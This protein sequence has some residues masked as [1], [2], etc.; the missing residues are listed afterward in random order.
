MGILRNNTESKLFTKIDKILKLL[1]DE[2]N[3]DQEIKRYMTY[4]TTSPLSHRSVNYKG[5]I[6]FQRDL[7]TS[8][9]STQKIDVSKDNDGSKIVTI[10]QV[11]FPYPYRSD[12]VNQEYCTLFISNYIYD[13]DSTISENIYKLDLI[14]PSYL[15]VLKPYGESRG[16]KIMERLAYLFDKVETDRES[17][18]ELGN[19]KFEL[20]GD[21]KEEKLV[22]NLEMT[23]F[24]MQLR[25]FIIGGRQDKNGY[26]QKL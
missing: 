13:C 19:L 2:I 6:Y 11:L 7:E 17:S 5:D 1:M 26:Y 8:L 22:N 25:T 23:I 10:P 4:L 3:K 18:V 24:S 16:H 20:V 15:L 9:I 12:K 14:I 21:A